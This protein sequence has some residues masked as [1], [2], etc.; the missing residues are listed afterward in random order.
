MI[1]SNAVLAIDVMI[2]TII[3]AGDVSTKE[4]GPGCCQPR[5]NVLVA[6]PGLPV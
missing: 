6:L 3:S 2:T 1:V 4:Q 5:P